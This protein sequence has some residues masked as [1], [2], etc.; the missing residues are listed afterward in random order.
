LKNIASKLPLCFLFASLAETPASAEGL[1]YQISGR[2]GALNN[3]HGG[4]GITQIR[5]IGDSYERDFVDLNFSVAKKFGNG[6]TLVVAYGRSDFDVFSSFNHMDESYYGLSNNVTENDATKSTKEVTLRY[7]SEH[8]GHTFGGFAGTGIVEDYGDY[9]GHMG[10]VFMGAE[11]SKEIEF[12][13]YYAQVGM[14]DSNNTR[15]KEGT[16]NAPFINIGGRYELGNNFM[17]TGSLGFAG[18]KKG[19]WN[20]YTLKPIKVNNNTF[21]ARVGLER[22]F[23]DITGSVGYEIT[24]FSAVAPGYISNKFDTVRIGDTFEQFYVGFKYNFG[25]KANHGSPLPSFRNWIAYNF[26]EIEQPS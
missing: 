4:S 13:G 15:F 23:G 8:D 16:Q 21:N 24:Q 2:T 19:V 20:S 17:L 10:Y 26:N 6:D 7:L 14:M 25:A 1:S 3:Q 11:I 12:G 5:G 22:S 18:G 9:V